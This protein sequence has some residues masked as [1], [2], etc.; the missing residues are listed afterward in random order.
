MDR[1][2]CGDQVDRQ[3]RRRAAQGVG[4]GGA[5]VAGIRIGGAGLFGDR[6]GIAQRAAGRRR[7]RAAR[8][9]GGGGGHR[10]INAIGDIADATRCAG[11]AA[12][13]DASPGA[14]VQRGR[15]VVGHHRTSR[16]I[17]SGIAGHQ[18]IDHGGTRRCRR[19]AIG[20]GDRQICV[21]AIGQA[22]VGRAGGT[23]GSG[24]DNIVADDAIGGCADTGLTAADGGGAGCQCRARACARL[25]VAHLSAVD[26]F[27]GLIGHHARHQRRGKQ[28]I[29]RPG[30]RRAADCRQHEAARFHGTDIHRALLRSGDATL[31]VRG[32][33]RIAAGIDRRAARQW[34]AGQ[35]TAA[36]VAQRCEQRIVDPDLVVVDAVDQAAAAADQ[37]ELTLRRVH[38]ALE[39]VGDAVDRVAGHDG[40]VQHDRMRA[41]AIDPDRTLAR[42]TG[43]VAADRAVGRREADRATGLWLQSNG[44]IV[45][46][47]GIA[48]DGDVVQCQ[49][50]VAVGCVGADGVAAAAG[51]VA[52]R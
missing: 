7:N 30:L 19:A 23:V 12:S 3:I 32:G 17:R 16:R 10:Q 5:V 34:R 43:A 21:D 31:I 4:V 13:A 48:T 47:G 41:D 6:R 15:E 1:I 22:E 44:R 40:A 28:H 25:G 38:R 49:R 46:A 9:V 39:V 36:V 11:A 8:G 50:V 42:T 26:G 51:V 2:G 18:G 14:G 35:G 29:Q 20:L 33:Q 52:Q 24:S 37:V 27:Y 45:G